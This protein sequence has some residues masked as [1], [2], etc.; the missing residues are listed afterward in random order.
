MEDIRVAEEEPI[1][2]E[3][4]VEN[5]DEESSEATLD[6]MMSRN[7]IGKL[8]ETRWL[9]RTGAV[10]GVLRAYNPLQMCF[11]DFAQSSSAFTQRLMAMRWFLVSPYHIWGYM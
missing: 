3:I 8:Y 10:Q 5:D 4:F 11:E 7:G 9:A 1:D 2:V 6:T